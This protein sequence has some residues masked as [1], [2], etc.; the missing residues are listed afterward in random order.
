MAI[1]S[2]KGHARQFVD[3]DSRTISTADGV[4]S[5]I[6]LTPRAQTDKAQLVAAR[7]PEFC[8]GNPAYRMVTVVNLVRARVARGLVRM[9]MR[10]RLTAEA[11]QLQRRYDAAGIRKDAR[12]DVFV[13]AD[14]DGAATRALGADPAAPEFHV[15]VF[16]PGGNLLREWREVPDAAELAAVLR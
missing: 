14:F 11:A 5:V 12:R 1:A 10:R 13:V 15:F 4:T 16:G 9:V 6:V 3:F 2:D 7:V 8:L